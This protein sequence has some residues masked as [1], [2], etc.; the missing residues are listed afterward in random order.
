MAMPWHDK[1]KRPPIHVYGIMCSRGGG[2]Y[3]VLREVVFTLD[4]II[5]III[6]E[7]T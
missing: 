6:E 3:T 5:W 4:L 2:K 7:P 1:F